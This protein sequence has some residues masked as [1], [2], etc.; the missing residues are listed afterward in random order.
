MAEIPVGVTNDYL[1]NELDFL[2]ERLEVETLD[3][4]LRFPQ[5]FQI[6]TIRH[7]NAR[8]PF[9]AIDK[10]DKSQ[11][12]MSDKLYEKIVE[13]LAEYRDWVRLVDIQRAG[14][15]LLDKKIVDRVRMMKDA[16]MRFVTISTNASLLD[17]K[18]SVGLL[19][20][21]LDEIMLSIDSVEKETYE[22]LRVQLNYEE[23]IENI[24]R[25]FKLRDEL[26]PD[27]IIRVRG[28]ACFD[29]NDPKSK[30][31][32][33]QWES[34]WEPLH[35]P[36][37]RIYM[38]QLHTWG[39]S[40]VWEEHEEDYTHDLDIKPCIAPWGTFHVTSMG[41]VPLCGQDMDAK[42]NLGNINEQSIL[43]VWNGEGFRRVRELHEVGRRNEIS[44][45]QGCRVFDPDFSIERSTERKGFFKIKPVSPGNS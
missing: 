15:P 2:A 18:K 12:F 36:I 31:E 41:I 6:E 23:V 17:E 30:V 33:E 39:N 4:A 19:E 35:S 8:C 45:C 22:R 38:K 24:T 13:E 29:T 20:A 5:F 37:D 27:T 32:M 43:E 34:F 14:E 10:W 28:V 42:M 11:P 26:R 1:H 40:H 25:F 44:F 7:C 16:G 9:C 3:D 21:G